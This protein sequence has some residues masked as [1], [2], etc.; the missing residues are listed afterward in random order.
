[1]NGWSDG[2]RVNVDPDLP[3][4]VAAQT[5]LHE[6]AHHVLKHRELAEKHGRDRMLFEGEAEAVK[7]V[8]LR[9]LGIDTRSNG[10]AYLRAHGADADLVRRSATR[11]V[12]TAK[13]VIEALEVAIAEPEAQ[14]VAAG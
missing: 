1:G 3:D 12:Q 11:I 7:V 4:G 2:A 13:E 8:V 10:A 5:L 9:H 6:L 14:P